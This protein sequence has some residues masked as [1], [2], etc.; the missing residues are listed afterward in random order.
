MAKE[1]D[2]TIELDLD[3]PEP[4][5][6]ETGGKTATTTP[7]VATAPPV[8]DALAE[9]KKQLNAKDSALQDS[10][11]RRIAAETNA[12]RSQK[13]IHAANLGMV[14]NA[15]ETVKRETEILE[16]NYA[17]AMSNGDYGAAAKI[18]TS[19]ATAAARLVQLETG[20]DAMEAEAK[21]PVRPVERTND[22][23]EALASQLSP[24]SAAW[25]RAHPEYARDQRL[26]QRMTAAHNLAVTDNL[27]ADTD[28][29]FEHVERTLGIRKEPE[30]QE[31]DE[32]ALSEAAAPTPR[33]SSPPAAPVSRSGTANG[34]SP[35]RI[36]L[37]AQER[38]IASMTG[39][40]DREYALQK[41]KLMKE[42][43]IN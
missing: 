22:P 35:N 30:V 32:S 18:Q 37:T 38:E 33:R 12:Q 36:T 8:D 10:E 14:N 39:M 16:A 11:N 29:Y 21:Q 42:G 31:D 28:D 2:L 6:T 34:K 41:Q 26:L 27:K 4:E 9:L 13:D 43:K 20:K 25:V 3:L 15:I 24:R 5:K 23:V 19:M 17:N 1:D 40:T 7:H